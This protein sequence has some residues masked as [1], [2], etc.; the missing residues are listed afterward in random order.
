MKSLETEVAVLKEQTNTL[1]GDL[2]EMKDDIKEIKVLLSEKFVTN[3]TFMSYKKQN[4]MQK[5]LIGIITA[6]FT[7]IV[8]YEITDI[9]R[10]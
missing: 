7:T 5:W 6:V 4:N 10:R 3:E 8:T 9:F 2:T 1:H